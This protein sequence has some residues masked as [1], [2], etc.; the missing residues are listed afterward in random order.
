MQVK[1][2][3]ILVSVVVL[4]LSIF[5]WQRIAHLTPRRAVL[6]AH[7]GSSINEVLPVSSGDVVVFMPPNSGPLVSVV[8]MKDGILGWHSYSFGSVMLPSGTMNENSSFTFLPT[9]NQTFVMGVAYRPAVRVV[10]ENG[11]TTFS[12]KVGPSSFWHLV[13]PYPISNLRGSQWNLVMRDGTRLPLLG[14]SS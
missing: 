7:P 6:T 4:L 9:G 3:Y 8:Y 12:T 2:R 14:S 11:N 5:G 10:F 13:V 1:T